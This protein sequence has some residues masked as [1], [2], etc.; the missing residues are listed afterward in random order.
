MLDLGAS[1]LAPFAVPAEDRNRTS[2][3]PYGGHRFEFR[4][5]GSSQVSVSVCVGCSFV[6]LV[7]YVLLF[8]GILRM[9]FRFA[10]LSRSTVYDVEALFIIVFDLLTHPLFFSQNVSLV[11]T[12]LASITADTFREFSE[13]I[14]A[15]ATPKEVAQKALKE[16]WKVSE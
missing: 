8:V 6:L 5:V 14:E 2:L 7:R 15:G 3:F 4:A 1:V 12:V 10:L 9:H 16:S 13:A 11:N